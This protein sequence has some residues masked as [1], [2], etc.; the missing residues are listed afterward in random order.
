MPPEWRIEPK[1]TSVTVGKTAVIDCQADALP[2]ARIE[3]RLS[4]GESP[5]LISGQVIISLSFACVHFLVTIIMYGHYH[6][7][8]YRAQQGASMYPMHHVYWLR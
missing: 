8:Y 1:D 4:Q 2:A 7:C 5:T 6:C 3:W